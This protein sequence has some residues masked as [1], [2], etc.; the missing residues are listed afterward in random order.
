MGSVG[1]R[2]GFRR[3]K[4]FI[5]QAEH[6]LT[7]NP[8][9]F[10]Q[11]EFTRANITESFGGAYADDYGRSPSFVI[12]I[13]GHTGYRAKEGFLSGFDEFTQFRD[14]IYR[15]RD[16]LNTKIIFDNY[17]DDE[18]WE[19]VFLNFT[20]RRSTAQPVLYQYNITMRTI[21]P[22]KKTFLGIKGFLDGISK[23]IKNIRKRINTLTNRMRRNVEQLNNSIT[24]FPNEIRGVVVSAANMTTQIINAV[25]TTKSTAEF[26]A[27]FP[28]DLVKECLGLWDQVRNYI[29]DVN[30]NNKVFEPIKYNFNSTT[31]NF[32]DPG[33]F[34][35]KRNEVAIKQVMD[36]L[37][38]MDSAYD[39]T[40]AEQN[41]NK[42]T[43]TVKST[44]T[45]Q[46][47]AEKTTGDRSQWTEILK[48]NGITMKQFNDGVLIGKSILIPS[49]EVDYTV[50]DTAGKILSLTRETIDA[51]TPVTEDKIFRLTYLSD[52]D[53]RFEVDSFGDFLIL[54]GIPNLAQ[55]LKN[56]LLIRESD[57]ESTPEAGTILPDLVGL[58]SGTETAKKIKQEMIRVLLNDPR[59]KEVDSAQIVTDGEVTNATVDLIVRT[60]GTYQ[61]DFNIK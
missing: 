11:E 43:Y 60:E 24:R 16:E 33:V 58:P 55:Q 50:P 29:S 59:V 13:S 35:D 37:K 20:L 21:A 57:Y 1:N 30:N 6:V 22:Y 34:T 18:H 31:T 39:Q 49:V 56:K 5:I 14:E 9:A 25:E 15:M 2:Y 12:N 7:I 23:S 40:N 3:Y 38:V 53:D 46:Q 41:Q 48:I 42:S 44:D 47:I 32:G 45:I 26:L 17:A 52:M 36:D 51:K 19:V 8:Q 27:N 54:E 4:G 28:K 10:S 61:F